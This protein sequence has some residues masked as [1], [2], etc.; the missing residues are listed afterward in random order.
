MILAQLFARNFTDNE[1]AKNVLT[2][3]AILSVLPTANVLAPLMASIRFA[4]VSPETVK[5]Y[6]AY[7]QKGVLL[8]D[9]I[10]TT[11]EQII[12]TDVALIHPKGTFLYCPSGKF[13]VSKGEKTLNAIW[14]AHKLDANIQIYKEEHAFKKRVSSLQPASRYEDDG[15]AEYGATLLK[16]MSM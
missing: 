8:Y 14:K 16:S 7:S 11:K 6:S 13:D 12:P 9:L 2:V 10:V 1:A 4:S 3:M 5:T 15:S